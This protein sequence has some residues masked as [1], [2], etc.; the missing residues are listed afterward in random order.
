[1]VAL[2]RFDTEGRWE[3]TWVCDGLVRQHL[4]PT[5]VQFGRWPL[6]PLPAPGGL[7]AVQ[8]AYA[9]ELADLGPDFRLHSADR[10]ALAPG[11]ARW[12]ALRQQFLAEHRHGDAEIRFFLSG[13]GLFYLRSGDGFLGLLCEAGEWVALPA[14]LAHG[15]DAGEA[16][17]FEALRLFGQPEGWVAEPT[18]AALP[19]LP[20]YDDFVAQ[21]LEQVGEELEG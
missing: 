13:T 2:A 20:L 6:R 17:A 8:A 16:P 14:G 15:F 9:E 19:A 12:P 7:D 21:L 10:V 5:G 11:D 3:E 18:G 1:M 4:A